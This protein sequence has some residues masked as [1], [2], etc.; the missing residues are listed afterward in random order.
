MISLQKPVAIAPKQNVAIVQNGPKVDGA[1]VIVI[2]DGNKTGIVKKS[3][4]PTSV[5]FQDLIAAM[6]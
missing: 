5:S 2:K 3:G 1:D 4:P 6:F